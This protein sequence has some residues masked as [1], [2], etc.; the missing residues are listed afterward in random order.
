MASTTSRMGSFY[1]AKRAAAE[2][3][4]ISMAGSRVSPRLTGTFL[5]TGAVDVD[6][7]DPVRMLWNQ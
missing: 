4:R 3:R 6:D 5:M 1:T 2:L 7:H